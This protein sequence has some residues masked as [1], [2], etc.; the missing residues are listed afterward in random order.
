LNKINGQTYIK[1]VAM[2]KIKILR[3]YKGK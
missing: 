2:T 3:E 1:K